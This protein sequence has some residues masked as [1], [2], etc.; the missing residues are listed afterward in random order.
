MQRMCDLDGVVGDQAGSQLGNVSVGHGQLEPVLARV[1]ASRDGTAWAM[2][3][4]SGV[5]AASLVRVE[6]KITVNNAVCEES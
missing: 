1:P 6:V 2:E 3:D 4:A 5:R